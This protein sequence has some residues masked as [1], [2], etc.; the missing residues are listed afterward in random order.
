MRGLFSR[1][2]SGVPSSDPAKGVKPG[3]EANE[4][5]SGDPAEREDEGFMAPEP[6]RCRGWLNALSVGNL[7]LS[8]CLSSRE[9][10]GLVSGES[11]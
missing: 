1:S 10:N 7:Q 5:S 8:R 6:V 3:S 9:G 2:L 11:W 4:A